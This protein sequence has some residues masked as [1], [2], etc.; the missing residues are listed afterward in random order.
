[1]STTSSGFQRSVATV[2]LGSATS[3]SSA[4]RPMKSW[5]NF[6][7][8]CQP[9]LDGCA[10]ARA[11][12]GGV[13]AA[14]DVERRA[15]AAR[16]DHR[17]VAGIEVGGAVELP[18]HLREAA[19]DVV[20]EV[21]PPA[22]ALD[23]EVLARLEDRVVDLRAVLDRA[24]QLVGEVAATCRCGRPR[25]SCPSIFA[26]RKRR[27]PMSRR[28]SPVAR[29]SVSSDVGPAIWKRYAGVGSISTSK[30]PV[31]RERACSAARAARRRSGT[32]A[33]RCAGGSRG[34]S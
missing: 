29:S 7:A 4:A 21:R 17:H 34:R 5:S 19:L 20:D 11:G 31:R 24:A 22:E 1:M 16:L 3:A 9:H 6:T 33:R 30:L 14:R 13:D 2:R 32:R 25:R 12:V 18:V 15:E 27:N 26:S 28:S 10:Q 23:A 8:R